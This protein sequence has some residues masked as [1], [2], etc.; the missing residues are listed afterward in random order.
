MLKLPLFDRL[1]SAKN[2]LIAG[3]GGGFDLFSGL[4]LFFGLQRQGATV[5]LASL[6]FTYLGGTDAP[7]LGWGVHE[8][9][10]ASSGGDYFPEKH[11][12]AWLAQRGAPQP[13]WCID[14]QGLRPLRRA[15]QLLHERLGFDTVVLVDGGTD[16]LMRGDE[17]DLGT[18]A[19]DISSILAVADLPAPTRLL[20]CL[21]FGIDRF[22]GVCHAHFLQ[23]VAELAR[24]GAY[25]G[26][27]S[28]TRE[29]EEVQLFAQ[30]TQ[31]VQDRTPGRESVVCASIL[32][33]LDGDYGNV[34][35]LERTRRSGSTLWINPLMAL[36]W[37]FELQA[38]A[39]RVLYRDW[40]EET[41]TL[42]DLHLRI[43]A[44]REQCAARPRE[45]IPV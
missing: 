1:R 11:L 4:P 36:Y 16:S 17:A 12:A 13:V 8:V 27:L 23:N 31:Y 9:T 22:H 6:S 34:H 20:V 44:F 33:A 7:H 24:A 38:V 32:S 26:A 10:A 3:A 39:D 5:H 42:A 30:A 21:G 29:M 28:L 37:A 19:E 43:E 25:C 18:P 40:I 45:E 2:V 15:Y 41:E 14:R 35:R